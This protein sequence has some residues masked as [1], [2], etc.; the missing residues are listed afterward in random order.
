VKDINTTVKLKSGYEMPQLGF[1]VFEIQDLSEC[2]N[3]VRA[4]LDAGYRHIDTAAIYG[5]EEAVG[6]A[7]EASGVAREDI[8][9]TTKV[10]V[11]SFGTAATREACE[12]SLKKL[13]TD[14]VDLYL[15]HW[16]VR[17]L[18][19]QTWD[20]M[21][22]MQGEGKIRSIGVSNFTTK[23]FDEQFFKHT[24]VV[25]DVNQIELHPFNTRK[26]LLQ[27]CRDKGIM[28]EAYSPLARAQRMDDPVLNEVASAHNKNVAQVM[29]R[30][31][32]QQGIVVIPK[33]SKP[34]R[35]AENADVYDF[36]LSDDE[37]AKIDGLNEDIHTITWRPEQNWF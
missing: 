19:D 22:V 8:F 26:D 5:N 29:I 14:Y 23:R 21:Q 1:G 6:E 27:Y 28:P 3:A 20:V 17:E 9:V 36:V 37:M 11:R 35:I 34:K 13:R 32:L 25:P 33:S 24:D 16:P 2:S 30:W 10:F 4:A 31:Q 18:V 15:I 12:G 7:I